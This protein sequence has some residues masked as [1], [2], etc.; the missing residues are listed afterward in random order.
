MKSNLSLIFLL[1]LLGIYLTLGDV[2]SRLA[3][4]VGLCVWCVFR[5]T[6]DRRVKVFLCSLLVLAM[7]LAIVPTL[8]LANRFN[9]LKYDLYLHAVDHAL[10]FCPAQLF[11]ALLKSSTLL[12][13]ITTA[14]YQM[15][16]AMMVAGY[17]WALYTNGQPNRLLLCYV[18]SA[19]C[20][21]LYWIVPAAGPGFLLGSE[22]AK[23]HVLPELALVPLNY[24][25]NCIPS[26]HLSS[27]IAIWSFS[28]KHAIGRRASF[29]YIFVTAFAT[30]A[31]GEHYLIDLIVALPFAVFVIS[32]ASG[33]Y[34][35]A[36][37]SLGIVLAWLVAI[38]VEIHLLVAHA[39]LLWGAAA[40]TAV[41]SVAILSKLDKAPGSQEEDMFIGTDEVYELSS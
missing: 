37:L 25:A 24:V 30:L 8:I 4:I 12:A 22:L 1:A 17:G 21:V 39:I 32:A 15:L 13:K 3:G 20:A 10:G 9:P 29:A 36:A 7:A 28:R 6:D 5:P 31:L 14:L 27:A 2:V 38:R 41:S 19:L 11:F 26:A 34:Q 18:I 40:L 33:K 35:K 16:P 23:A